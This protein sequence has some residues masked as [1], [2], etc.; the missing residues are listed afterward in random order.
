[1]FASNGAPPPAD[2]VTLPRRAGRHPLDLFKT[3]CTPAGVAAGLCDTE[4]Q[5]VAAAMPAGSYLTYFHEPEDDTTGTQ[6][7]AAFIRVYQKAKQTNGF[8]KAVPV[9][10]SYQ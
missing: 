2:A 9:H 1:M 10:M 5:T 4:I 8:N 6:F 3:T 7:V